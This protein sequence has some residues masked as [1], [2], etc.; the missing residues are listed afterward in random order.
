MSNVADIF[1]DEPHKTCSRCKV[2][3]PHYLFSKNSDR[4]IGITP[5]C[6]ECRRQ[7]KIDTGY[8]SA[9]KGG[10][11]KNPKRVFWKYGVTFEHVVLTLQK[12]HGLCANRGCGKEIFLDIPNGPNR[13][14]IDHCHKTGKFR[15]V[16]CTV[17]NMLCGKIE[18]DRNQTL[19][20]L[21]YLATHTSLDTPTQEKNKGNQ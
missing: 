2:S 8:K 19:G 12:Q 4:K 11:A 17:C 13:A 21:D 18:N 20:L 14:V 7:K 15:A 16:L 3:K 10:Y 6:L 9:M 5:D 1:K